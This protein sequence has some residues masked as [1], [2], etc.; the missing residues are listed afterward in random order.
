MRLIF[1]GKQ[2]ENGRSLDSYNIQEESTLVMMLRLKGM[3]SSFTTREAKNEFDGFLLGV[4]PPPSTANFLTKWPQLR[5]ATDTYTFD[6]TRRDLLS[7]RQHNTIK[8]FLDILWEMDTQSYQEEHNEPLTDL[9]VKFTNHT[10]AA[11][12]LQYKQKEDGRFNPFSLDDLLSE[13]CEGRDGARIALRCTRGPGPGAISWHF[14]GFYS[15]ETIQLA[16]N[17]DTEYEGGRLCYFTQAKGVEVLNRQ[18][19]DITKHDTKI[20]HAVTQLRSGSRYS[21]FVVDSSNGLGDEL[22]VDPSRQLMHEIMS[23]IIAENN[24][25]PPP[26]PVPPVDQQQLPPPPVQR[27]I[28]ELS[29]VIRIELQ[30]QKEETIIS[31]MRFAVAQL[32]VE[33]ECAALTSVKDKL[34]FLVNTLGI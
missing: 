32:G 33:E 27:T 26:P 10:A 1:A 18:V 28:A 17:P 2:L 23:R 22:V 14:D 13:H 4:N 11:M 31:V 29:D 20:L 21:L 6:D 16:L 7:E 34:N 30:I 8:R 5:G 3:I 15:S 9:K 12:L 19:G 25:H 24:P